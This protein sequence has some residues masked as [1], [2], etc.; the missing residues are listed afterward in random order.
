VPARARGETNTQEVDVHVVLLAAQES[1]EVAH[2]LPVSP[3]GMGLLAFGVLL[4]GLLVTYAFKS[5]GTRH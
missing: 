1:A 4:S 2:Q 3:V 5:V